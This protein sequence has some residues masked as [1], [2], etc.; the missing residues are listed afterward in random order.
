MNKKIN[1]CQRRKENKKNMQKKGLLLVILTLLS[2]SWCI[3]CSHL[4]LESLGVSEVS[5]DYL[6]SNYLLDPSIMRKIDG[7]MVHYCDQGSGPVLLLLHGFTASLHTW[8]G[9][10]KVLE[11]KYRIIRLD[12]LGFGLTGHSKTKTYSRDDWIRFI[13]AFVDK[14][15]LDVFSIA[16]NSLG[17]Y[18]AWNYAVKYPQKVDKLILL[19]PVGYPQDTPF[20]L[21]LA[22]FPGVG[23]LAKIMT[24][25]IMVKLCLRDVYGD[26]SLITEKLVDI[27]FDM[28]RR[29]GAR[30][31]YIDIF[32]KMKAASKKPDIGK[33]IKKI[34][35]PTLIMWGEKDRWVPISLLDEWKKA[36]PHAFVKTYPDLGHIPMEENPDLTAKDADLFLSTH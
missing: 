26:Q 7:N 18:I 14:L 2:T 6:F 20:L 1:L 28:S 32:R 22:C 21:N 10:V 8:E 15:E 31:A 9:W 35:A 5:M 25:R 34:T 17:G 33:D 12:I 13:G 30:K 11:D 27:Y 36:V 24:P 16:G 19:D 3:G 29:P 4:R 23:E